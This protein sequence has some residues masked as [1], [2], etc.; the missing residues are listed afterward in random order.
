M[1]VAVQN[2]EARR[3]CR[4]ILTVSTPKKERR[5][6]SFYLYEPL[7]SQYTHTLTDRRQ[8]GHDTTRHHC[9]PLDVLLVQI[10]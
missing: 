8:R 5:S 7:L 9:G 2:E 1:P 6:V 10:K 3:K 4:S